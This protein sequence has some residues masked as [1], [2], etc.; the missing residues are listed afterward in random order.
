MF[1]GRLSSCT[2][3]QTWNNVTSANTKLKT[4]ESCIHAEWPHAY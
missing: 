3:W 2:L 1:E 4:K